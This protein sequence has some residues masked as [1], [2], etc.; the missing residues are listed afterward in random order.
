MQPHEEVAAMFD[1]L[2]IGD[3][4]SAI[5]DARRVLRMPGTSVRKGGRAIP[6]KE[7]RD[8]YRSRALNSAI[9]EVAR[10]R[11]EP[12]ARVAERFVDERWLMYLIENGSLHVTVFAN[13]TGMGRACLAYLD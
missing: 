12:V 10:R 11:C 2:D 8:I 5:E 9:P 6:A 13:E 4:G 7:L 1:D 3:F